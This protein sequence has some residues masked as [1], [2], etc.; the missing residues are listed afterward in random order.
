MLPSFSSISGFKARSHRRT[1]IT[2]AAAA[3]LAGASC[4]KQPSAVVANF[5]YA[6]PNAVTI[7]AGSDTTVALSGGI[8]PYSIVLAPKSV[9]ATATLDGSTLLVHGVGPMLTKV[10]VGDNNEPQNTASVSITVVTHNTF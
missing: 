2:A 9:V 6:T 4:Q 1:V 7:L 10:I 8:P 3:L 5:L